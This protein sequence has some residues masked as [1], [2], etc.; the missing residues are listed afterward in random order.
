MDKLSKGLRRAKVVKDIELLDGSIE[1]FVAML[2]DGGKDKGR[3]NCPLCKSYT[4]L[5][6]PDLKTV[7]CA[8]CPIKQASGFPNCRRTPYVAW[9]MH[10]DTHDTNGYSTS[11][12]FLPT[13]WLTRS[14]FFKDRKVE[15]GCTECVRLIANEIDFLRDVKADL[16]KELS[17]LPLPEP[18]TVRPGDIVYRD[19][20]KHEKDKMRVVTTKAMFREHAAAGKIL[21]SD[22]ELKGTELFVIA[23]WSGNKPEVLKGE[24]HAYWIESYEGNMMRV[25]QFEDR[26]GEVYKSSRR[27]YEENKGV[28]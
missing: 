13:R 16:E 9:R 26:D 1:K 25:E 8:Q 10:S 27:I 28:L 19:Y 22:T 14:V 7:D 20:D 21:V 6:N 4:E 12:P 23:G 24:M 5:R 17:R 2:H 18:V 3:D 11:L 15:R